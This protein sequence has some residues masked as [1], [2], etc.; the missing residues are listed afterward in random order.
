MGILAR[1]KSLFKRKRQT[2]SWTKPSANDKLPDE[3]EEDD[4]N[5]IF[6]EDD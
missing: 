1:L 3:D 5:V 6:K 2:I 4:A